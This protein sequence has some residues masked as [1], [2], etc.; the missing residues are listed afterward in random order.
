MVEKSHTAGWWPDLPASVRTIGSKIAD[1]FAPP[2]EAASSQGAYEITMEIPG[3]A[4]KDVEITVTG[5][6]VEIKGQKSS[7]VERKDKSY[8]FSERTYGA[9]QRSFRLPADAVADRIEAE[10]KDGVLTVTIP[11]KGP[12]DSGAKKIAV[13]RG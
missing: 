13:N 12:G 7:K 2:S 1:W 10:L 5:D 11:R 6:V 8:F 4:E 3:V 9:F